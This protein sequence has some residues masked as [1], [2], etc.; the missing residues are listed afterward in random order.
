MLK[1][2]LHL[3]ALCLFALGTYA[4]AS[5]IGP[6]ASCGSCFG[7]SYTL[8][9]TP[10]GNANI[11]NVNFSIDTTGYTGSNTNLLNSV[12]LK[13]V[14]KTSDITSISL[15]SAP[16]T[17]TS[18]LSGG[19]NSNGCSGNGGGFFCSESS[20]NGLQVGH[21]GDIYDFQW[22]VTLTAPSDLKLDRGD[23][24][25]KALYVT[26]SGNKK[27]I[28]SEDITLSPGTLGMPAVPEPAS[29]VL[30]GTGLL[31][32]AGAIRRRLSA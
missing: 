11:F 15:V 8:T 17:F 14:P 26:A 13:I 21:S 10:T 4:Q 16:S 22:L 28:T 6:G 24:S 12:S 27:G 23:A 29:I 25:V 9:Y 2:V 19:L 5:T 3:F 18:T 7:S 1:N 31:G 20:S 30:L 32:A